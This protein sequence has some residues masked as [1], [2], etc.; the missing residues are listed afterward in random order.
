MKGD[1]MK[2]F[3]IGD[4]HL[5]LNADKPMD[6]FGENWYRHSERIEEAWNAFIMPEDIVLL[7]GDLSWAMHLEQASE[8]LRLIASWPG[9]KVILRG[10]HDYWWTSI[11]KL[12]AALPENMWAIQNDALSIDGIAIGGSRGWICPGSSAFDEGK[13]KTIYERECIRL[14]LSLQ[15]MDEK[16]EHRI[17]ML[18]YPPCNER[19]NQSVF[20]D[21]LEKYRVETLVYGHLHGK[22]CTNAFEDERNGVSYTLC[23]ADH[24][25]F[26]PK[27]IL[28]V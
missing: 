23:S 3:A 27:L 7:P 9:K 24:L 5:S 21:L 16:A 28:E 20:M 14:E 12:R 22:T 17:A 13:D 4:L 19:R 18:H 2:I 1:G 10:N 8:D 25:N 6:V 15:R 11:A 26:R